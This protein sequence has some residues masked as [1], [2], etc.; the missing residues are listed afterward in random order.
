MPKTVF[1]TRLFTTTLA[2]FAL[3]MFVVCFTPT[4]LG[5]VELGGN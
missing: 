1:G 4:P 3:A 2:A 5:I